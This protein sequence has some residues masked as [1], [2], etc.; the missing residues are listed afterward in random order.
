M[1]VCAVGS[2][3]TLLPLTGTEPENCAVVLPALPAKHVDPGVDFHVSVNGT[4]T[5][6]VAVLEEIC[7]VMVAVP[8]KSV[9]Y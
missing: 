5:V 9:A 2:V 8:L 7:A 4:P 1:L 6:A 3:I